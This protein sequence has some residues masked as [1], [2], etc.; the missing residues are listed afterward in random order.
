MTEEQEGFGVV[1]RDE[2]KLVE[3]H[4]V[5]VVAH[6][7]N[8]RLRLVYRPGETRLPFGTFYG[9]EMTPGEARAMAAH[10]IREAELAEKDRG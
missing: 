6:H 4:D 7:G 10:M 1:G 8:V 2:F 3:P 9:C 5:V